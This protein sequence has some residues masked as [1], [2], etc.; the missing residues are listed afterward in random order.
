MKKIAFAFAAA[1][2]LSV[3]ACSQSPEA[4]AVENNADMLA[5]NLEM[6]ADNMED[7]ADNATTD[8]A[9]TAMENSADNLE[10][11][12][13]NVRDAAEEKT[14]NMQE[15]AGLQPLGCSPSTADLGDAEDR[16]RGFA[17][18]VVAEIGGVRHAAGAPFLRRTAA[19]GLPARCSY[20]RQRVSA[21]A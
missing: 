14:D 5:D 7:M 15:C 2:L 11:A 17:A 18:V 3:A 4:A 9:A 16:R 1:G 6:Q 12:A 8:N 10:T 21:S 13:D 19:R 20:G